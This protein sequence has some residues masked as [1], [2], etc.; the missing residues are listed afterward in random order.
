MY[1]EAFGER[2]LSLT[3]VFEW[4][5]HFKAGWVSVEDGES[6]G[7][8]STSKN[9]RKC[10]NNL[11]THPRRPLQNNPW[12]CRHCWDQL[13]TLPRDLNRK[14]EYALHCREVCSPTLD[15]WPKAAALKRV[16]WA[17]REG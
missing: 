1:Y 16:S 10:W 15:K 9:D 4:H 17:T 13:W 12:A 2:S 8:P 3:A 11:R 5:T 7:R 14:F 6:S